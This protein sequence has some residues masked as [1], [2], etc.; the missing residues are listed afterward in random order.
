[1]R[2]LQ[3][4][5]CISASKLEE[6]EP[7]PIFTTPNQP[8]AMVSVFQD[9]DPSVFD[10][11][12]DHCRPS[13]IAQQFPSFSKLP[14]ELRLQIW[15][16]ALPESTQIRREWNNREFQFTLRRTPP[17]IIQACIESRRAFIASKPSEENSASK[18]ELVHIN[19]EHKNPGIFI[20]WKKDALLIHRGC[21]SF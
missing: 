9:L 7:S 13:P 17:A 14:A 6:S 16:M 2:L 5:N 10:G 1:M 15:Q 4:L 19:K 11:D 21:K 18:Y 20:D 12:L 8:D 3:L